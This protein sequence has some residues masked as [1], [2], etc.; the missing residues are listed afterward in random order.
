MLRFCWIFLLLL[1]LLAMPLAAQDT[2]EPKIY[3]RE[4]EL[5]PDIEAISDYTPDTVRSLD[6]KQWNNWKSD[7][8]FVYKKPEAPSSTNT[9]LGWNKFWENLFRFFDSSPGKLLITLAVA[10]I[11]MGIL[12]YSLRNRGLLFARKDK[13]IAAELPPDQIEEIIPNNWNA[14]VLQ[15]AERKQSRLALR[16]GHRY[17]LQRLGDKGLVQLQP[18][19]TN[20]QYLFELHKTPW[21]KT[22]ADLTRQYEYSWYGGFEVN[23]QHFEHF[24]QS[25][26]DLKQQLAKAS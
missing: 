6:T 9:S 7:E 22:F 17:L 13:K 14:T 26:M 16:Y 23:Q 21:H 4:A 2:L 25:L 12:I 5:S 15:L 10:L 18:A 8:A 19:K 1:S 20:Y 24:Y 3:D 11:V